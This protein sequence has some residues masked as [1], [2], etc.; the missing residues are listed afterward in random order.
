MLYVLGMRCGWVRIDQQQQL[1][2]HE[3]MDM[4]GKVKRKAS[5][6]GFECQQT[7]YVIQWSL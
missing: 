6:K 3:C 1:I 2:G 7:A 4:L 5:S